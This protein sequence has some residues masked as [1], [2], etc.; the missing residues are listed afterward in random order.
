MSKDAIYKNYTIRSTPFPLLES[1]QWT[2]A[3]TI[4][5]KRDGQV[6]ARPFST[7]NIYQ[8]EEEADL[9]GIIYGRRIINGQVPGRSVG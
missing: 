5:W 1:R 4:S 8:T 7:E 9:E 2:L 6:T 3:I